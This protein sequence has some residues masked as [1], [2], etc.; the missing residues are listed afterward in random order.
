MS[1]SILIE[2]SKNWFPQARKEVTSFVQNIVCQKGQDVLLTSGWWNSFCKHHPE[3]TLRA[4]EDFSN[5]HYQFPK[6]ESLHCYFDLLQET[7]F[8]KELESSPLIF[9]C[10]E[11]GMP[12]N[13]KP[14]KFIFEAGTHHSPSLTRGDKSQITVLACCNAAGIVIPPFTIFDCKT[15]KPEM[16]T[17]EVSGTIYGLSDQD[18]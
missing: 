18:G 8:A 15:L 17:V 3:V 14:P 11:T 5:A 4:A 13:D 12:L 6:S 2:Y 9:N 16:C 1:L 7:I 10:D